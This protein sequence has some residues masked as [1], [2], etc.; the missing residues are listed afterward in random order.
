MEKG[1]IVVRIQPSEFGEVRS[2]DHNEMEMAGWSDDPGTGEAILLPNEND[3]G[4]YEVLSP[5]QFAPPIGYQPTPPIDQLIRERVAGELE[6]LR[7]D[8]VVDTEEDLDDFDVP[9]DIPPLETIYEVRAMEAEV[10]KVPK[11]DP[12]EELSAKARADLDYWEAVDR[13][14]LLR[15]RHR[16]ATLKAQ[17]Q[18]YE[19]STLYKEAKPAS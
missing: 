3:M 4:S 7:G 12:K 13:E 11:V 8:A 17:M 1:K 5:L 6:R 2:V 18:E 16:E 10:P 14:R 19:E 15:K 9:D